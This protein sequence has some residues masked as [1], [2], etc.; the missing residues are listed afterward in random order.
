M[1]SADALGCGGFPVVTD[2]AECR[3]IALEGWNA[4]NEAFDPY[5]HDTYTRMSRPQPG[6]LVLETT[7]AFR[8]LGD[9]QI[10][11]GEALGWLIRSDDDEHVLR[12]IF[13][14][15]GEFTWHNARFIALGPSKPKDPEGE[16]KRRGDKKVSLELWERGDGSYAVWRQG[17]GYLAD[18]EV[19]ALTERMSGHHPRKEDRG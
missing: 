15:E 14:T 3:R 8:W 19:Q 17:T 7:T 4:Y 12:P 6:D 13:W 10:A 16:P 5:D 1:R 9:E 18:T 11:P 2:P